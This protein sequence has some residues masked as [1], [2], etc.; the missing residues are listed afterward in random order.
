MPTPSNSRLT[1]VVSPGLIG[2][3]QI[4][5]HLDMGYIQSA[6]NLVE[7]ERL[8]VRGPRVAD[9]KAR[10]LKHVTHS[11]LVFV[12]VQPSLDGATLRGELLPV[13]VDESL[14]DPGENGGLKLGRRPCLLGRGHLALADPA[15]HLHPGFH[16]SP[17]LVQ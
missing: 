12:T 15:E 11:V 5:R 13:G 17:L 4:P 2:C 7:S 16:V 3:A 9:L 10:G 14:C 8:A 1:G 6:S